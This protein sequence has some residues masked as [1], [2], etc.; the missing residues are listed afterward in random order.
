MAWKGNFSLLRSSH[1]LA[2]YHTQEMEIASI[3]W[4]SD[5]RTWCNIRVIYVS[6]IHEMAELELVVTEC[7]CH[8]L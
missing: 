2:G 7:L 3:S 5:A 4:Q 8:W 6:D 1:N